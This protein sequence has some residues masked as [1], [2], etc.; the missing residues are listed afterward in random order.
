MSISFNCEKSIQSDPVAWL[1]LSKAPRLGPVRSRH[2]LKVFKTPEAIIAASTSELK[3]YKCPSSARRWLKQA[4]KQHILSE[5]NWLSKEGHQFLCLHDENYPLLLNKIHDAP[6]LLFTKG[7]NN[8]LNLPQLAIVGSRNPSITGQQNAYEFS[9]Y[10]AS[11]GLTITSGLAQGVDA[12]AHQG[13]LKQGKTIAVCATGLD[14]IYPKAHHRLAQDIIQRGCLVSE[15]LPGTTARREYFPRRNRL[16]SGLSL[17]TLVV[18]ASIKSGSLIT[19]R[20]ALE[21]NREVFAIP[22]S[23]HNPLAKGC[24]YLIKHGAKLVENAQDIIEELHSQ[25]NNLHNEV[26]HIVNKTI[27]KA[28]T[29]HPILNDEKMNFLIT[30]LEHQWLS[31]DEIVDKTQLKPDAV[32]SMLLTLEL[33]N[34]IQT[35]NAGR[36]KKF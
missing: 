6:I 15:F 26:E 5:L 20:M 22:G 4:N 34:L 27:N 8:I 31:I 33:E 21:Q 17:G 36:Y 3:E 10:L 19:A 35:D 2:L 13:A 25:F 16:I 14:I 24:H 7:N 18:E 28:H 12:K 1:I 9:Q 32:S 23:I 11:G 30:T 29:N